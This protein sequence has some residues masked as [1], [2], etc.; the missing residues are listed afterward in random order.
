MK[1]K[2][3]LSLAGATLILALL[4]TLAPA[5]SGQAAAI[6][7]NPIPLYLA[8]NNF[9]EISLTSGRM[10]VPNYVITLTGPLPDEVLNLIG[11]NLLIVRFDNKEAVYNLQD[12]PL[13]SIQF[14]RG[15]YNVTQLSANGSRTYVQAF[16]TFVVNEKPIQDLTNFTPLETTTGRRSCFETAFHTKMYGTVVF[17]VRLRDEPYIPKDLDLNWKGSLRQNERVWIRSIYCNAGI[18]LQ[19]ERIT[20]TIGWAKEWGLSEALVEKTFIRPAD[21]GPYGD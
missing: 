2:A 6:P 9:G 17:P 13:K 4:F 11:K 19:I 8:I 14:D 7:K 18:W 3:V 20:G 12:Y 15:Y 5:Q 21:Q 16:R 1:T 10:G